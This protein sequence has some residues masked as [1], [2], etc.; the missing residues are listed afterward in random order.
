MHNHPTISVNEE[1][2]KDVE[3]NGDAKESESVKA[4]EETPLWKNWAMI[5]A[6]IA[7][8]F[9]GL[10]D[11]AY[12]EV[13]ALNSICMCEISLSLSLYF[14]FY[15]FL[16]IC[17]EPLQIFSLWAVSPSLYGGL[18]FTTSEVANVLAVA[19]QP[20]HSFIYYLFLNFDCSM[21]KISL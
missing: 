6:V 4:K 13:K 15:N 11:M 12:S 5:A 20:F 7:Y 10:H 18:D 2:A 1:K 17:V 16:F 9:W 8:C 19:G 14:A 21:L 3:E